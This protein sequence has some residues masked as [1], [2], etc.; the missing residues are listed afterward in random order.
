MTTSKKATSKSKPANQARE[1][2]RKLFLAGIGLVDETNQKMHQAF[3][4]LVKK[5]H[6]K[7]PQV[8]KAIEDIRKKAITRRKELE[9]KFTDLVKQ[10]Q[11]VKSQEYQNLKKKLETLE[12]K[13]KAVAKAATA[14]PVKKKVVVKAV[15]A[16]KKEA[17]KKKP[18][19]KPVV[20]KAVQPKPAPKQPAPVA[21]M[22]VP[23][24]E[25]VETNTVTPTVEGV[26]VNT[27]VSEEPSQQ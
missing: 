20:Q 27:S 1:T 9:K 16:K 6:T 8:K 12:A 24:A 17:P 2:L 5:G 7:E 3:N 21:K 18:V 4:A 25:T 23:P 26:P 13:A 22:V 11:V 10:N 15:V 14:K 19:A